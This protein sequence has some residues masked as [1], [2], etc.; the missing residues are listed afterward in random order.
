MLQVRMNTAGL[1]KSSCHT[2]LILILNVIFRSEQSKE[3]EKP[4]IIRKA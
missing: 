2:D 4:S 3:K 1:L